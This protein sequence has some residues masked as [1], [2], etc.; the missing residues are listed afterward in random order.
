MNRQRRICTLER[1]VETRGGVTHYKSTRIIARNKYAKHDG[2]RNDN[3]D[4]IRG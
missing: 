4:F 3:G 1:L 2:V